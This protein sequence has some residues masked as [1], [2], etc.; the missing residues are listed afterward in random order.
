MALAVREF[1]ARGYRSLQSIAYPMSGLDVFVGANGVGKT[2]LYR[3]LELL[4]S[5]AANTLALDLAKEGGLLSAL[6]AGR[7]GKHEPAE[8]RLAVGLADPQ[9]TRAGAATYLYEVAMGFPPKEASASFLNEPQIKE[10]A[11]SYVGGSRPLRLVERKNRSVMAR[12][13]NGRP[14]VIDIDLLDSETILGR[15]EDPSRYPEL[16]AVRRTL[17]QW[18]FYHSLRTD[19]ASPLRE[20]CPAIATPALASDGSNLAAVFATLAHIR[21]DRTDL[22]AAVD[23]AFPGAELVIPEP[24]SMASFGMRFPEF[25]KR[26]FEAQ[27]LSDGTLRFLALA[28]ALLAYRLPPFIALNEPEASLHPD[29]MKPLAGLIA[30][31][32]TRTQLWLVTHST[33]LAEAVV[34]A[35]A[36]KVRTVAKAE[37][38]ATQ[39]AGLK[40]W[41]EFVEEDE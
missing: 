5:A 22:D 15:I 8:V 4:Q 40:R 2:N 24:E 23:L 26:V 17:L 7:R 6:W 38:G 25:P 37:D 39:I 41:G 27:E 33:A 35:G 32:A 13:D 21:E 1:R 36:G 30:R 16:D 31:A 11:V 19:A 12:A 3:A 10:E 9:D 34:E 28:G 29:L 14:M 18:R 20:A